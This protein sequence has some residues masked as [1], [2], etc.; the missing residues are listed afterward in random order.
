[1]LFYHEEDTLISYVSVWNIIDVMSL[2]DMILTAFTEDKIFVIDLLKAKVK[3]SL[4]V[5]LRDLILKKK[6]RFPVIS[7]LVSD[8]KRENCCI[9]QIKKL[10]V[11]RFFPL[12]KPQIWN[13]ETPEFFEE[14]GV[15]R[16]EAIIKKN[17]NI[18][19]PTLVFRRKSIKALLFGDLDDEASFKT[20]SKKQNTDY[21]IKSE[22]TNTAPVSR[23]TRRVSKPQSKNLMSI[24]EDK[25]L[26]MSDFVFD[27]QIDESIVKFK[28]IISIRVS[29]KNNNSGQ[30]NPIRSLNT[31]GKSMNSNSVLSSL[32]DKKPIGRRFSIRA[33]P[34]S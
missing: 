10:Y 23:R 13:T 12:V 3:K 31:I 16:Y 11:G 2:D 18:K 30:K 24:D 26:D 17:I 32:N 7:I 9:D 28:R 15:F 8:K 33:E 5:T 27:D 34:D 19:S 4:E 6:T 29:P 1:M 20:A 25:S 21:V 22:K 14:M